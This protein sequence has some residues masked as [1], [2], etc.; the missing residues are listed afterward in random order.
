MQLTDD[1]VM[2]LIGAKSA[3]VGGNAKKLP[4]R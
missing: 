1:N 4:T 2:T 3:G